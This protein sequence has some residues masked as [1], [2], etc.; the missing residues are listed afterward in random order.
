VVSRV[1]SVKRRCVAA[2][3]RDEAS[4]RGASARRSTSGRRSKPSAR[5]TRRARDGRAGVAVYPDLA[6]D[7]LHHRGKAPVSR[8]RTCTRGPPTG[9]EEMALR[10][11]T[12]EAFLPKREATAWAATGEASIWADMV[13]TQGVAMQ[14]GIA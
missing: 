4:S 8:V 12:P 11:D 10:A 2:A 7:G 9:T 1:P 5:S 3:W 14:S 6:R 13:A